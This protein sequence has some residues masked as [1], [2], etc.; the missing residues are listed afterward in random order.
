MQ[1]RTLPLLVSL[2]LSVAA[3]TV[4]PGLRP[5]PAHAEDA[6][7][8][9][10]L[11]FFEK[12]FKSA[13]KTISAKLWDIADD[14][15]KNALFQ[16]AREEADRTLLYFPDHKDARE[17][18]GYEKKKSEWVLDEDKA[19]TLPTQNTKNSKESQDSFDKR[20]EKWRER[21]AQVDEFIA[22]K[23]AKVGDACRAKGYEE[24]AVKA[25]LRALALDK[26]NEAARK[27]LGYQKV[28]RLW[29]SPAQLDAVK[30]AM[31]GKTIAEESELEKGLGVKLNKM[32]TPHFR[33]ED[34]QDPE[35]LGVALKGLETL[36][37]FYLADIGRDP[38]EDVFEGRQAVFCVVSTQP[39]WEK[40]VDG[41]SNAPDKQW[42]KESNVYVDKKAL[43][44]G[45]LR[46]ETADQVDTRDPLLHHATH[47]LNHVVWDV[48]RIAWL[49]EG[50]A[51]YY[52]VKLQETTRTHC[53]QKIA[54][55]YDKGEELGGEKD[56]ETSE[57]WR[58]YLRQLVAKKDDIDL[59]TLLGRK[60]AEL[61]LPQTVKGWAVI[62]WLMETERD[63]FLQF[64]TE[65]K[66]GETSQEDL[67]QKIFGKGVEA[68]DKDWREYA[69][70]AY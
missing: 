26:E 50:L 22:T 23:I 3:L 37:C 46:S 9:A 59:R 10:G 39:L 52:T 32:G 41:F 55:G 15:R 30:R 42:T 2:A 27:G 66:L 11:A 4:V 53:V 18:L 20:V 64:L 54:G 70:R 51:Y 36:Y 47:M 33:V 40:W 68:I 7:D 61:D 35:G 57:F 69:A 5:R 44:A 48:S 62:T 25:Y 38:T 56:W 14:A 28:G 63:R 1:K 12:T 60:L 17:F 8:R 24:Q 49:D 65:L 31:D 58:E 43:R 6:E 13:E 29:L 19:K 67:L 16:F 21:K 45:T 34:D